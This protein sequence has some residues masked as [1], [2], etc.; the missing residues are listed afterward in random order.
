MSQLELIDEIAIHD[1]RT[2]TSEK[3]SS[4]VS[5]HW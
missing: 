2:P 5:F 4:G 1:I 3:L